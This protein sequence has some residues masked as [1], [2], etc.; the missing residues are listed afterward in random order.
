MRFIP[1]LP[2]SHDPASWPGLRD[3]ELAWTGSL[4]AG[5]SALPRRGG[6]IHAVHLPVQKLGDRA[7]EGAVEALRLAGALNPDFL[8]LPVPRPEGRK[9]AFAFL[10]TVESLLEALHP[11]GLKLALRPG[12]G[13]EAELARLMK[14]SRGEAVGYCWHEGV[15]DLEAISDRLFC[16]VGSAGADL[17]PLQRL[18]YRWNLALEAADASG[19]AAMALDLEARFPAVVF[20]AEMPQEVMGRPVVPDPL[21]TFGRPSDARGEKP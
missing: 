18:G 16:A 21:V 20:P 5:W 13:A 9:E 19:F 2:S 15:G 1:L 7:V 12:P 6:G 14:E 8:V 4:H 17:A 11:R 3:A 10:G